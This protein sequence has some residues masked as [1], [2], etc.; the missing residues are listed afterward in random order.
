MELS[1]HK[2]FKKITKIFF[3]F[4]LFPL[5]F[6]FW[7]VLP[8]CLACNENTPE[9]MEVK[10]FWGNTVQCIGGDNAEFNEYFHFLYLCFLGILLLPMVIG[11][12]L[13]F[14]KIKNTK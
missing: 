9:N 5:G 4:Y 12:I 2:K 10:D 6:Y 14:F 8:E 11:F 3:V 1:H 7:A 13:Y